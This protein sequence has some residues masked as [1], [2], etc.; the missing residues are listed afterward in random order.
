PACIARR[1]SL[2]S[3]RAVSVL[4]APGAVAGVAVLLSLIPEEGLKEADAS[5]AVTGPAL[6]RKFGLA[7]ADWISLISLTGPSLRDQNLRLQPL[8]AFS[9]SRASTS[10]RSRSPRSKD[11]RAAARRLF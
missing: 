2:R 9:A 8:P 7:R 4:L 11:L 10:A 1:A 5:T 3:W 6:V